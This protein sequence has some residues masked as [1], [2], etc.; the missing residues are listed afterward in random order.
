MLLDDRKVIILKTI[1][2]SYMETGEPI[3]SR[4]I[5]KLLDFDISSATI[6]NEMSDLEDMGYILQPHTSSGRIPSDKGY[7]FYVDEILKDNLKEVSKLKS[8]LLDR[9]DKIESVLKHLAKLIASNTNYAAMISGPK[10]KQNKLKFIQLSSIDINKILMVV[11]VEGNL[12]KNKIISINRKLDE[13]EMLRLNLLLNTYISGLSIEEINI[14]ILNK[15]RQESDEETYYIIDKILEQLVKVFISEK[16]ELPIYTSGTSNFFK[17]PELSKGDRASEL[18]GT[19]EEKEKL[20]KM[21][22]NS[23]STADKED[24]QIYIGEELPLEDMRD[25]SLLTANYEFGEGIRGT[26]GIV[27]PKRMDYEKVIKSINLVMKN[28]EDELKE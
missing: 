28:L 2:K 21:L 24:I 20:R 26:I 17:Y 14:S 8:N 1:I 27:G 6:R 4:T 12:V 10:Y 5:S 9:V 18:V 7:R 11:V 23:L 25:C 19:F 13:K 16:E 3:G 22:T 15:L